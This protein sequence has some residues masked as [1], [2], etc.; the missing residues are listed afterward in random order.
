MPGNQSEQERHADSEG[1]RGWIVS[2]HIE[3][4][5]DSVRPPPPSPQPEPGDEPTGGKDPDS[6][7]VNQV[8]EGM[9]ADIVKSQDSIE[10]DSP[11]PAGDEGPETD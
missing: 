7:P 11:A 9:Y 8:F 10:G 2:E 5:A 3:K 4:S 6:G 1:L